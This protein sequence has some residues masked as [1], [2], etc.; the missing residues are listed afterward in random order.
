[1]AS[2]TTHAATLRHRSARTTPS[3][4]FGS[5]MRVRTSPVARTPAAAIARKACRE[6]GAAVGAGT[7][8]G[9][10]R[11]RAASAAGWAASAV[12]RFAAP[13]VR[14]VGSSWDAQPFRVVGDRPWRAW[15]GYRQPR[16]GAR[17]TTSMIRGFVKSA[18]VPRL[19]LRRNLQNVPSDAAHPA[20]C[21]RIS[22]RAPVTHSSNGPPTPTS[23]PREARVRGGPSSGVSQP[24]STKASAEASVT[25]PVQVA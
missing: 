11:A 20:A 16:A 18:F 15:P 6:P 9:R 2:P 25:T 24:T 10:I 12:M 5:R 19:H 4:G 7:A 1:V 22:R 14:S 23:A 3:A 21:R 13:L 8:P 17:G